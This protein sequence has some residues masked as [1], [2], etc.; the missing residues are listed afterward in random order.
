MRSGVAHLDH[1]RFSGTTGAFNADI[2]MLI[3][4]RRRACCISGVSRSSTGS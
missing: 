1:T 2:S 3:L 4:L